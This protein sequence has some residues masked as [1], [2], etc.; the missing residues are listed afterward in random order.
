[1]QAMEVEKHFRVQH[2]YASRSDLSYFEKNKYKKIFMEGH[3]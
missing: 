2:A 1:M 3:L